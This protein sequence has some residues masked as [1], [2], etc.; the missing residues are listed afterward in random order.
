MRLRSLR[1]LTATFLLVFVAITATTG[2]GIYVITHKTIDDLVDERIRDESRDLVAEG[3][4][5][6]DPRALIDRIETLAGSRDTGDLGVELTDR[7]GRRIAGN[8]VFNRSLPLGFSQ[9]GR[10]DGIE[11]L[12]N[13]RALARDLGN[14]MR[15]IVAAETEPFDHYT[16]LRLRIFVIGF[17]SIIATVFAATLLFAL[18]I[19]RRIVEMRRTVDAIIDGD[20]KSR[21]AVDG[22]H[23]AFDQQASAFNQMLDRISELMGQISNTSNDIAHELRTPL[24]RL[25]QRLSLIAT[26]AEAEPLA[27]DLDGALGDVN[28]LL[29][30]FGA[31]LRIAEIEAGARRA[32]FGML[33]LADLACETVA[34]MEAVAAEEGHELTVA[35]PDRLML[36]GDTQLL[37]QMLVNL[38]ENG[39][40]HTPPG[41]RIA[42]R[43]EERGDAVLLT[44]SDNGPGIPAEARATALT[45]FGRARASRGHGLGLPLVEA[46]ARLHRGTM[47]LE[48]AAPGLRVCVRLPLG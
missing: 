4:T 33:D 29:G 18:T 15:L 40:T 22:S 9:L 13:G 43:L 44:V 46:I 26:R 39:L 34:M 3:A 38:V 36:A 8:V 14:G 21:V 31:L 23:S 16:P 41:T 24:T 10:I 48:D 20:M 45:R 28:E 12:S 7:T 2:V 19:R 32:G 25:H 5:V 17:G 35:A 42:V 37:N 11:G 30:M 47:V 27:D 6:V 1:A